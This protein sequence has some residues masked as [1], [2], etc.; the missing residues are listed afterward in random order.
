MAKEK[1]TEFEIP[2]G[3]T[4]KLKEINSEISRV[5]LIRDSLMKQY[6]ALAEGFLAAQDCFPEAININE[7]FTKLIVK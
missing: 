2:E 1:Q 4:N 3:L 6:Q 7:E 5:N